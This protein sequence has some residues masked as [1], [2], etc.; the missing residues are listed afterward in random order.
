MM[1]IRMKTTSKQ[2]SNNNNP[3]VASHTQNNFRTDEN[4]SKASDQPHCVDHVFA[5]SLACYFVS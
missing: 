5:A 2:G 3:Q 4:N 1:I